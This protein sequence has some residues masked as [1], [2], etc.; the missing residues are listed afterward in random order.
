MINTGKLFDISGF[1]EI[2]LRRVW[3]IVIPFVIVM[4]AAV[5]YVLFAPK[6]YLATTTILVTPQKV[7]VDFVRPTVTAR[8]EDRLQSIA[9]EILSR[10]RLEQVIAE[11]HLY[12]KEAK[13][14]TREEIVEQMRRDVSVKIRG[15]EG[16]FTITYSGEDP[17]TVTMVTN[18]LASL[19]IEENL[20]YRELLAQGTTEFLGV[21][22]T[23]TKTKLEELER[24]VSNF[25]R[26]FMNELP[27]QRDSNLAVLTQLQRDHQRISDILRAGQDRKLV[28]QKQLSEIKQ[29][30]A[31]PAKMDVPEEEKTPSP[32]YAASAETP[33]PAS[34]RVKPPKLEELDYLKKSLR[35]LQAK[36]T[37]KHP[38]IQV[39]K[40]KVA[41]LEKTIAAAM[42]EEEP[43]E[44]EEKA[45]QVTP[46]APLKAAPPRTPGKGKIQEKKELDNPFQR[47]L[48]NQVAANDMEIERLKREEANTRAKIAEYQRRVENAPLRELTMVS[49]NRDYN[50]TKETY[51][52]LLKKSSEAQQAENLERRQKGEQF[53]VIDPARLPEKPHKPQ[54]PQVLLFGLL[55]GV[56]AGLGMA[57]LKEQMDHTFRDAGDLESTL[58]IKVLANIPQIAPKAA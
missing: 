27:E 51:Q 26:Q 36:Y 32:N 43:A 28:I 18:K 5:L 41:D 55:L 8:I 4:T 17:K 21:E 47:E 15:N 38:D 34:P 6:V 29:K 39:T 49:L 22:L 7:P 19:F 23:A 50:N 42:P 13:T 20:K 14:L 56:G 31:S 40:K 16:Y 46:P 45:T 52:N 25:K 3:Y 35:E 33:A 54:I 53:K 57:F 58:E 9:Q 48:E 24:T 10:T 30:M 37:E 2:I 44:A 1:I 11:F 12:S